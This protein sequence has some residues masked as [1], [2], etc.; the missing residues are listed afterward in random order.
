[1]LSLSCLVQKYRTTERYLPPSFWRALVRMLGCFL[2]FQLDGAMPRIPFSVGFGLDTSLAISP[3]VPLTGE[4]CRCC[5]LGAVEGFMH[6][7]CGCCRA[8]SW[9]SL[10][11]LQN[12]P[13]PCRHRSIPSA[14]H[15]KCKTA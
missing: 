8:S 2:C 4:L 13:S 12:P 14:L 1:M 7:V 6:A 3:S 10:E 15:R 9:S 11:P 5:G